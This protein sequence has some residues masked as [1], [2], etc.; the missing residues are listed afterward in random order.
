[1]NAS[2]HYTRLFSSNGK[3]KMQYFS[4]FSEMDEWKNGLPWRDRIATSYC[5]RIPMEAQTIEL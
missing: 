5:Q 4:E 3:Q 2:L 1:V